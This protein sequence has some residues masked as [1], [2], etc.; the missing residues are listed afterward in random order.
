MA[1]SLQ[2]LEPQRGRYKAV[3]ARSSAALREPI[4]LY[5]LHPCYLKNAK[6]YL[7][8]VWAYIRPSI[9]AEERQ[10][11]VEKRRKSGTG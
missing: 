4:P 1:K 9:Y 3:R 5:C 2:P 7:G 8:L 10:A 11:L 6:L